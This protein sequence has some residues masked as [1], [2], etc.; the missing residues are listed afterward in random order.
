MRL[1]EATGVKRGE[2][3]S[4]TRPS[5]TRKTGGCAVP[6]AWIGS[7][8]PRGLLVEEGRVSEER[9]SDAVHRLP[10]S[11][12]PSSPTDDASALVCV[13]VAY[14]R[15]AHDQRRARHALCSMPKTSR[16]GTRAGSMETFSTGHFYTRLGM[17]SSSETE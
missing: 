17:L 9:P 12:R 16:Q 4:L 10:A 6:Q 7:C 13:I 14:C 2:T 8:I 15:R 1:R 3:V 11:C 5:T